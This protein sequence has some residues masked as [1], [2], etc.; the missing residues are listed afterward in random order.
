MKVIIPVAGAGVQLRPHT[1]TQPKPLIPVAGKPI[2][3]HIIDKLLDAGIQEFIFVIG[4]L[5][6]KIVEYIRAEYSNVLHA[7]F[8]VQEPRLGLAHAI[9]LCQSYVEKDSE[10]L[11]SLGDIIVDVPLTDLIQNKENTLAV[12]KVDK[13]SAFGIALVNDAG[14]IKSLV[15]KP[16]IPKSNLALVGLYKIVTVSSF[17]ESL[18]FIIANGIKTHHEFHL[19][20]VL[21]QLVNQ[22]IPIKTCNVKR[23]FDC[24]HKEVL[25][26]SNRLLL[27]NKDYIASESHKSSV[28]IP[29]VFIH[30]SA[31][32][33][34]SIIGPNVAIG[35]NA[36]IK[37]S[38]LEDSIVGAYSQLSSIILKG[39]IVGN[40]SSLTG[41]SQSVNIGDNTDI[42][43]ND[44][45]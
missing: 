27:K 45:A 21:M 44:N 7:T 3:G 41:R 18:H 30:P 13:P 23:W 14:Y 5:G 4:Y 1:H 29:P 10:F 40:D 6:D 36:V 37:N 12:H 31:Q 9:S 22:G 11:I 20:D 33:Q 39:S 34:N 17:F 16:S 19:T 25:L 32:L 28:I 15:E 8:V 2:L 26:E 24:G 43:F 38:I 42:D 35:E